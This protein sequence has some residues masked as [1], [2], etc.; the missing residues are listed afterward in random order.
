MKRLRRRAF[1]V[2]VAPVQILASA[3][4]GAWEYSRMAADYL[5]EHWRKA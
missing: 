1:I 4:I 3:A 2:L 5:A